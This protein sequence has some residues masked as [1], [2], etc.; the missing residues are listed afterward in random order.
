MPRPRSLTMCYHERKL[1]YDVIKFYSTNYR[2]Q[3][4]ARVIAIGPSNDRYKQIPSLAV[5]ELFFESRE[6]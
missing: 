1:Y 3:W 6:P 4:H 2:W 5:P